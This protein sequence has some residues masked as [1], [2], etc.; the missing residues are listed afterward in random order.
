MGAMRSRQDFTTG[1]WLEE[2]DVSVAFEHANLLTWENC[3]IIVSK[4]AI[5]YT[6]KY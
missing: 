5:F 6:N 2:G 4:K 3:Q 1:I